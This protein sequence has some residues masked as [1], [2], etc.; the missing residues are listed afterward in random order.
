MKAFYVLLLLTLIGIVFAKST[1]DRK[2]VPPHLKPPNS[3]HDGGNGGGNGPGNGA[4]GGGP[5]SSPGGEPPSSP[6]GGLPSSGGI[7]LIRM[8]LFT[9]KSRSI[10]PIVPII[11]LL[12]WIRKKIGN[13]KHSK[14]KSGHG[15]KSRNAKSLYRNN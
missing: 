2:K 13:T 8:L 15:R 7:P 1:V 6:G 4:P 9:Q 11:D 3:S 10:W 5:P 14:K 12:E